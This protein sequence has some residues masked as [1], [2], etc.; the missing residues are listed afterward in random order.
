M[1]TRLRRFAFPFWLAGVRLVRR[2]GRIA[3]V[4]V[5]LAAAAAMLAGVYSGAVAAQDRDVGRQLRA[6]SPDSRAIHV[7]W[8]SVG[9]QAAPYATLDRHVRRVLRG[10]TDRRPTGTSL[11]R[12]SQLGGAFLSLGAVDNLGRWVRVR[13]GRLPRPCTRRRCEVLV[14]RPGGRIPNVPGLRLVPV[15]EGDVLTATLFGDAVP[16]LGL[17]QSQFFQR[18][19]RYHR[20]APPPL[21]L[22]NGVAGLDAWPRLHDAYRTYSWV[23]P[24]DQHLVRS[25]SVG[26]LTTRIERARALLQAESFGF[27]VEAPTDQLRAAAD[28]G[29]VVAR[30]LLLLGGEAVA[31][32]LAFAVLAG[33]RLRPDVE[34]S[35]ER[36]LAGG[37]RRW[38]I[39]LQVL[40][41]AAAMGV[42]GVVAGWAAGTVVAA[43]VAGRAGEPTG[44]L[45]RHSVLSGEGLL[46]AVLLL[47]VAVAL[48]ALTLAVRPLTYRGWS[49]SPLDVAGLGAVAV[50]SVA[51]VRGAAD[52]GTL[53]A[54]NGTGAMLLL[55]PV[56]VG[57][58]A[59]VATARLLPVALRA[60]ERAVPRDSLSL[61]LAALALARRPGRAAVAVGFLVVAV[62]LALF[63]ET[64]RATLLRGQHDQAAF[65]VPADFLV[66][67]DVSQLIPVRVAVTPNV[68]RSLGPVDAR[69]VMRQSGSIT[70]AAGL[71]SIAVLGLDPT[72]IAGI[73]GWR[74]DFASRSPG[75]LG[76]LVAAK[77]PTA[78]RGAPL[79]ASATRLVLPVRVVGTQVGV[80]ASVRR[81][82]G[83]FASLPLGHNRGSRAQELVSVIPPA[84]RGG[85]LVALGFTPPP[86]IVEL[87][88]DQGGPATGAVRFGAPLAVTR[89]GR[90][91]VTD[92]A[93]WVG[94]AGIARIR[95]GGG[96]RFQLSLTNEVQT[97]LRPRQS[98]DGHALPAFVSPRLEALAGRHGVLG[99]EVAGQRL[100]FRAVA[101]ARRFPSATSADTR[102]FVVAD[103]RLVETALNAAQPG[104]GFSTELWLNAAPARHAALAARLHRPPF[105][106]LSVAA[107]SGLEH[108]LR[109]DP[110]ARAAVVM[111]EV[112]SVTAL[113][114]ALVGLVLGTVAERRDEAGDLFDLE[115]Q[116][117]APAALRLQL[118]LRALVLALSGA[119]G[120]VVTAIVLS[121]LVVVFV[122]LTANA[123][124]PNPPLVISLDWPVVLLAGLAGTLLAAA[125]VV[126]VSGLGFREPVPERYGEGAA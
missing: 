62:G 10:V 18:M 15:G 46:V 79:P 35:R 75:A 108:S 74:G 1:M 58:V 54:Q 26:A 23:V 114:L 64:Y 53:L 118:R 8:F 33:V 121:L 85:K 37:G 4:A 5:G 89:R 25:W 73:G 16:A 119:V 21:V 43:V 17:H 6:L 106:V 77:G 70:G 88:G 34:A 30:R 32:L 110:V 72:S 123:G 31:L 60:L 107:R 98:T 81:R 109:H 124:V 12:E 76:K 55:L 87:G 104:A 66:R 102:D 47:A 41:E 86:R 94:T 44:G 2:G 120:G 97:Y 28:S 116:G 71:G 82:D 40:A 24:L 95:H 50:I 20:P 78:L 7:A 92:Y 29:R 59:A 9:G 13:S 80:V 99:L 38:Q 103:R 69:P 36:L 68:V 19:S 3:L 65:A 93:D 91:P 61:R 67:E 105:D 51:L 42:A 63:A 48:L 101:V 39:E 49:V 22:A 56:L 100:L 27:D 117:L 125:F 115:A 45:L 113:V 57:F 14:I 122:E 11:Y 83:S 84:A 126:L 52:A 111:L 112:A 90:V 96:V